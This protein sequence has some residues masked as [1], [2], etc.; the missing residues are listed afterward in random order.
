MA[1][2][3]TRTAQVGTDP[4][5]STHARGYRNSEFISHLLFPRVTVPRRNMRVLKFGKNSFR[6]M[7]TRR[8]PGANKQHVQF[9]YAADPIS[10]VQ[11]LLVAKVPFE[12]LEESNGVPGV[13]LAAQN[14]STVLDIIDLGHEYEA[15][16]LA[17]TS[18]NYSSSNQVALT[19]GDRWSSPTSTPAADVKEGS[20]AIRRMIGRRRW[21]RPPIW[22]VPGPFRSRAMCCIATRRPGTS[23]T[24]TTLP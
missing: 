11:N 7:N 19:G 23:R 4:V 17:R 24:I 9:G 21:P 20:N 5:L 13:D 14:V 3:N 6:M 15:A 2:L 18:A 8:A 10:L 16:Q 22:S 1:P 12:F